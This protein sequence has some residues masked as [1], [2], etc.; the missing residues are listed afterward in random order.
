[1]KRSMKTFGASALCLVAVASLAGTFAT[2]TGA[3]RAAPAVGAAAPA[4]TLQDQD[5]KTVS[6]SDFA[7]KV[8]VLEWFNNECPFVVKHYKNG[9]MNKLAKTY[10]DQD[11]TWLAINTTKGKTNADN[12]KIAGEWKIDR[13]ILNDAEGVVGHLYGAQT[14]PQMF[15]I[16]KDGTLV[17]NGAIDSIKSSDTAD[18]AKADNYVKA[19]LDSLLKGQ[20]IANKENKSYGCSV[21]Y[22]N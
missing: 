20:T 16:A 5:G 12:K 8:V 9:D 10:I 3:G 17:Y 18:I 7:G 2:V 6:L 11:V 4:F 21:K 19:A 1:M 13:P 14:T 22:K 15:I